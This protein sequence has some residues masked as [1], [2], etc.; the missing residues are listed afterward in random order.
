MPSVKDRAEILR[1][2]SVKL[3]VGPDVDFEEIAS[4]TEGYSGADLQAL[5]YNAHLDMVHSSMLQ[6]NS[7]QPN[8]KGKGKLGSSAAQQPSFLTYPESLSKTMSAAEKA[9]MQ[10]RVRGESLMAVLTITAERR[11]GRFPCGGYQAPGTSESFEG[12]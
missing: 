5:V 1:A 4:S 2:V 8:G 9:A 10:Q 3:D 6:P 11:L 12:K 7:L